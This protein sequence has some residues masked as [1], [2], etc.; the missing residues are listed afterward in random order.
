MEQSLI[1]VGVQT[2]SIGEDVEEGQQSFT[3]GVCTNLCSC[4]EN[5][6]DCFSGIWK[7][8]LKIQ[9]YNCWAYIQRTFLQKIYS[10]LFIAAPL[11]VVRNSKQ[12]HYSSTEEWIRKMGYINKGVLLSC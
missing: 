1:A 8:F 3:A 2:C 9:L 6:C 11:T 4:Y 7:I 12:A 5:Q 10:V